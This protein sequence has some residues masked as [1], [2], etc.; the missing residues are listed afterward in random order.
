M[1]NET[2]ELEVLDEGQ[3]NEEENNTCCMSGL[4]RIF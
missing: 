3:S 1:E 4:T 2:V